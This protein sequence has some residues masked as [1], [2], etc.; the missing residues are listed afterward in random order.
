VEEAVT[1]LMQSSIDHLE[2]DRANEKK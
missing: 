1:E 2:P